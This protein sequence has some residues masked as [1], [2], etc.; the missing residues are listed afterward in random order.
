MVHRGRMG[1]VGD[2]RVRTRAPAQAPVTVD[3]GGWTDQYVY[4]AHAY[5]DVPWG[6]WNTNTQCACARAPF[7]PLIFTTLGHMRALPA[8]KLVLNLISAPR[9]YAGKAHTIGKRQLH[10]K[11]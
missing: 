8:Q 5:K 11:C 3:N 1:C 7:W 4:G 2:S 6:P 9:P 10:T